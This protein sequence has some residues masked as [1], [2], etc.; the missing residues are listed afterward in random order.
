MT[1]LLYSLVWLRS[2]VNDFFFFLKM[3]KEGVLG[4]GRGEERKG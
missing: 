2:H 3:E 1:I 4:C